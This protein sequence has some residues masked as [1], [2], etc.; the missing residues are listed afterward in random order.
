MA[1]IF[2]NPDFNRKLAERQ[3][4]MEGRVKDRKVAHLGELVKLFRERWD[5]NTKA[6]LA[7]QSGISEE[8][9]YFLEEGMFTF[10]ELT[11]ELLESLAKPLRLTAY[12]MARSGDFQLSELKSE[13]IKRPR[14]DS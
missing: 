14:C 13:P 5:I 12:I 2:D 7:E 3:R 8:I 1:S 9:I 10:D 6:E 11:L 4:E